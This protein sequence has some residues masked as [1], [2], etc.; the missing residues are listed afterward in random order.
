MCIPLFF[1]HTDTQTHAHTYAHTSVV[2][3]FTELTE[4]K[5]PLIFKL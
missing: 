4:N 3:V 1:T 5:E 2:I